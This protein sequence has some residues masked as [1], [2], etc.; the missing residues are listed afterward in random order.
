[1]TCPA[2]SC[3]EYEGASLTR[4]S[5]GNVTAF[6]NLDPKFS[7]RFAHE[8]YGYGRTDEEA[9]ADAVKYTE[10]HIIKPSLMTN[11][12]NVI[13][14]ALR[15]Y[16]CWPERY[17]QSMVIDGAVGLANNFMAEV[18]MVY[19]TQNYLPM[20]LLKFCLEGIRY[21]RNSILDR[22]PLHVFQWSLKKMLTRHDLPVDLALELHSTAVLFGDFF[23]DLTE[24]RLLLMGLSSEEIRM[25]EEN[26]AFL[27]L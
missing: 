15:A 14:D 10:E 27:Y 1:M 4:C 26:C 8:I 7:R 5:N 25:Y 21:A 19:I 2:N 18:L 16:R 23:R 17:L 6:I 24:E 20:E 3:W 11:E 13:L 9:L 12:I 22:P